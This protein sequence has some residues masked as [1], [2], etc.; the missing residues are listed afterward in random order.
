METIRGLLND[1]R[2]TNNPA[3]TLADAHKRIDDLQALVT[4]L[5]ET[6]AS[7]EIAMPPNV[8]PLP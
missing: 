4:A 6:L 7:R 2:N 1:A 3:L 5:L 8:G